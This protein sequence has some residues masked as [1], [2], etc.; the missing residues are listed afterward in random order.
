MRKL[1]SGLL[2]GLAVLLFS[3]SSVAQSG[4]PGGGGGPGAPGGGGLPGG[5]PNGKPRA[6]KPIEGKRFDKMVTEMFRRADSDGDGII[7]LMEVHAIA[8]A[9]RVA[10]ATERFRQLDADGNQLISLA[11][12]LASDRNPA[13]ASRPGDA[14]DPASLDESFAIRP[15][16]GGKERDVVLEE[17]IEPVS[18]ITLV[19]ANTNYDSGV[20]L[21]ELLAY[22]RKA[23]DKADRD[24]DGRLSEE[25]LRE[26][27]GGP[28]GN[29]G[30]GQAPPRPRL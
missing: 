5:Q 16:N 9:K 14:D 2:L 19:N 30:P 25:E 13:L 3:P 10:A 27:R 20:S 21:E 7:T 29:R 23:F 6:M 15:V 18:A 4:P 28:G 26:L 12:F 22:E 11:E 1:G 17:L 8:Q 24:G